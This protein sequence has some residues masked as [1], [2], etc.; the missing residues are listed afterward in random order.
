[1]ENAKLKAY[2]GTISDVL[3]YVLLAKL[4]TGSYGRQQGLKFWKF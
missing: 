4:I 2:R 3:I 1:M